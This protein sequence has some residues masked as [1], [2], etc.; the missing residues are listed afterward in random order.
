M[1]TSAPVADMLAPSPPREQL[2]QFCAEGECGSRTTVTTRLGEGTSGMGWRDGRWV[3]QEP[4]WANLGWPRG[5][6]FLC[7]NKERLLIPDES[8]DESSSPASYRNCRVTAMVL[9]RQ[10]MSQRHS[11]HRLA[12]T[13]SLPVGSVTTARSR[14]GA[15]LQSR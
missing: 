4:R 7:L 15:L 6:R 13:E 2:P 14:V 1:C 10:K 5:L 9:W 11:Q 8:G 12:A 3:S